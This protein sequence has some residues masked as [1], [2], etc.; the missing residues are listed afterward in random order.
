MFR[1]RDLTVGVARC[2]G[3]HFQRKRTQAREERHQPGRLRSLPKSYSVTESRRL[4]LQQP[5]GAQ[6][7]GSGAIFWKTDKGVEDENTVLIE[8]HLI[9]TAHGNGIWVA[10][11]QRIAPD[12]WS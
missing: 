11:L 3:E 12:P 10:K 8:L 2:R 9:A 7:V 1:E 5:F 6:P 4:E